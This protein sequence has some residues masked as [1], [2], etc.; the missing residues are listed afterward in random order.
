MIRRLLLA[1]AITV[2]SAA[3]VHVNAQQLLIR[4][5]K[6]FLAASLSGFVVDANDSPIPGVYV[7]RMSADWKKTLSTTRSNVNG[8]FGFK[9]DRPGTYFLRLSADGF[10]EYEVTVKVVRKTKAKPMFKLDVAT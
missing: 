5:E 2:S 4:V 10:Q 6:P 9:V 7:E 1:F 8:Y 3:V